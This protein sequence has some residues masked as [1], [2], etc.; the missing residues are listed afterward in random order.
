MVSP[1]SQLPL[2]WTACPVRSLQKSNSF[3]K[4]ELQVSL[5]AASH[6]KFSLVRLVCLFP[7]SLH[8]NTIKSAPAAISKP[9]RHSLDLT[10]FH[11]LNFLPSSTLALAPSPSQNHH[12]APQT[13]ITPLFPRLLLPCLAR[14][15]HRRRRLTLMAAPVHPHR[16]HRQ[17]RPPRR[18]PS[19]ST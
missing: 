3:L 13:R 15:P 10:G 18:P 16:Q 2:A 4:T 8:L 9:D 19:I 6:H 17:Y 14:P 12:D 11:S 7:S 5:T 1:A